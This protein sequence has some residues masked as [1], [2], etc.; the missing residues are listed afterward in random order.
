MRLHLDCCCHNRLFD[1]IFQNDALEES[2][3][4]ISIIIRAMNSINY[5]AEVLKN[6]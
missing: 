4:I 2:N 3:A 5:F 6:G 1:A